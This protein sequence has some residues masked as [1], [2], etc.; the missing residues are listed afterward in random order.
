MVY[1]LKNDLLLISQ[2]KFKMTLKSTQLWKASHID[3]KITSVFFLLLFVMSQRMW[4]NMGTR[5]HSCIVVLVHGLF[6]EFLMLSYKYN[7]FHI[8]CDRHKPILFVII[9]IISLY[10][11]QAKRNSYIRS[12]MRNKN[13]NAFFIGKFK[14]IKSPS[15]LLFSFCLQLKAVIES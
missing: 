7:T 8:W 4:L 14:K 12:E 15:C 13:S 5:A 6:N 9:N 3:A 11:K 10:Y 1:S 2:P